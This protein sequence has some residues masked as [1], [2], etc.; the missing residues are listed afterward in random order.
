MLIFCVPILT[1]TT[2]AIML[3]QATPYLV[4]ILLHVFCVPLTMTG[5]WDS[6]QDSV[7]S[8]P[9]AHRP[10]SED[11]FFSDHGA[12]TNLLESSSQNMEQ[13]ITYMCMQ[14][15]RSEQIYSKNRKII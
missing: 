3:K 10:S 5:F 14:Y 12:R 2:P 6:N 13:Y 15:V 8:L 1:I 7:N 11:Y 4:L 9:K